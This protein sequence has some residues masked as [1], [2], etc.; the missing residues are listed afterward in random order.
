MTTGCLVNLG[1]DRITDF[2]EVLE[3]LLH[4]VLFGFLVSLE[5]FLLFLEG[6]LNSVLIVFFE[7]VL[8]LLLVLNG[9][10]HLMDVVFE[11]MLGFEL[12]LDSLIL[13]RELFGFFNHAVNIGFAETSLIVGDS[14]GLDL[15]CSLLGGLDGQDRV[16]INLEGNLDLGGSAR[17]GRDSV[18][19]EFTELMVILNKGA[20]TFKDSN[21]NGS[22]LVLVGGESLGFLGGDDGTSVDDLRQDTS[23]GLNSERKGSN[24]NEEDILGLISSLSSEN[25]SLNG[26]TIS[27]SFVGVNSSVGFLTIE[28]VLHELLNLGDTGR[29]SNKYDFVDL[30][31]L[32]GGIIE[33]LLDRGDSLLE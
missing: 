14:D 21:G 1:D 18:N 16:L 8:E 30:R 3:V 26:S 2:L 6:F 12:L 27:D 10:S 23:N 5:P 20:F 13:F 24:I 19:I 25:T 31:F 11:L 22:L 9:V 28:E 29:S 15:T 17:S 32:H 33:N 4:V 7:F